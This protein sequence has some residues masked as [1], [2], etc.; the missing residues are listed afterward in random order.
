M[1]GGPTRFLLLIVRHGVRKVQKKREQ[2]CN[3]R[4][5]QVCEQAAAI[6]PRPVCKARV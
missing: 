1:A 4:A 3:V 6:G 5:A 2:G